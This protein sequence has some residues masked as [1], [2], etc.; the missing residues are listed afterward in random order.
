MV[1]APSTSDN[2][3][4]QQEQQ[5]SSASSLAE[6]DMRTSR[7][8][9]RN[10]GIT[11]AAVCAVT[12]ILFHFAEPGE[13]IPQPDAPDFVASDELVAWTGHPCY[14]NIVHDQVHPSVAEVGGTDCP[15]AFRCKGIGR[16]FMH[17]L[18]FVVV[19]TTTVGYGDVTPHTDTGRLL[20]VLLIVLNIIFLSSL[21]TMLAEALHA[22]AD[23]R[24]EALENAMRDSALTGRS[25]RHLDGLLNEFGDTER[26]KLGREIGRRL[27]VFVLYVILGSAV[28]YC[29]ED[30]DAV[31]CLYFSVVT[32]SSVGYGDMVLTGTTSRAFGMVYATC[33]I[34]GTVALAGQC[35]ELY[36]E[37]QT[38]ER[39][40]AFSN[41]DVA[42]M[43]DQIDTDRSGSIDRH[44]YFVFMLIR[45]G[46]VKEEDV[47]L[48]N[49][50]FDELDKN[51]DGE[52]TRS[53]I[54]HRRGGSRG[55]DSSSELL[56]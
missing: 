14:S 9:L 12:S 6:M 7:H 49:D 56:S 3:A 38:A 8:T 35:T 51:A 29:L 32:V 53:T 24:A 39:M 19:T 54:L 44:E 17:S 40:R 31:E 55:G 2:A 47:A 10:A 4:S 34:F 21:A 50:S 46:K 1:S 43:F 33:G 45:S 22:Q 37:Q 5:L 48:I 41:R 11:I 18:Y 30:W 16:S 20:A 42:A 52:V 15:L 36:F 26:T 27:L 23:K 13:C 28:F 25:F